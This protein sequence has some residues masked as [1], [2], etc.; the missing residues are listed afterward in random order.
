VLSSFL[1]VLES[2]FFDVY[3]APL[4]EE[5]TLSHLAYSS[6]VQVLI[7]SYSRE[8]VKCQGVAG[9]HSKGSHQ[10]KGNEF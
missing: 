2:M 9:Y 3:F 7:I 5:E 1:S 6:V 10:A 4:S 8:G